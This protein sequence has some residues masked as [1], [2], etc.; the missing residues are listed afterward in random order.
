MSA[1]AI[2]TAWELKTAAGD[3]NI[4]ALKAFGLIEVQGIKDKRQIRMSEMGWRILG[5]APDRA[6]LLKVAALSPDIHKEIW[7]KY[8]G[9]PP[10]SDAILKDYLLWERERKFNEASV[11]GFIAQFRGTI[12]YAGLGLSDKV[13]GQPA[14]TG[15]KGDKP[16]NP[17]INTPAMEPPPLL[18]GY[19]D[20]PVYL[21]NRQRGML[22]I[23]A[24]MTY[25]DYE[26]L[27]QQIEN[28][29]AIILVTSVV[30][31]ADTNATE[32]DKDPNN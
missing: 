11:D 2:H 27:K 13:V 21:T 28:H 25:K 3:Q 7:E 19:R 5:N 4:A 10:P 32:N 17:A 14:S 9:A 26:L 23:P 6:E 18:P 24:E 20:F 12:A 15:E 16:L 30:A 8:G 29:L 1:P 22:N 31:D